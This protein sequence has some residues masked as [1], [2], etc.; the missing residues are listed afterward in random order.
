MKKKYLIIIFIIALIVFP[1]FGFSQISNNKNARHFAKAKTAYISNDTE[2]AK[3]LLKKIIKKDSVFVEAW[4]L[5]GDIYL[6]TK[7]TDEAVIAYEKAISIDAGFFPSA[8]RIVGDIEYS[9]GRFEKA[10]ENFETFLSL[11]NISP[12]AKN[13]VQVKLKKSQFAQYL[14]SHPVQFNP[15][16]FGDSINTEFDEYINSFSINESELFFTK[17]QPS[18]NYTKEHP[19]F[20]EKICY[21]NKTDSIWN[22]AKI[23]DKFSVESGSIGALCLSPD[24]RYLFFSGCHLNDGFGSC[25]LYYSKKSGDGWQKP[26][27]LGNFVNSNSWES[28]PCFSSDGKT[29]YFASNRTGGKGSSDIWKTEIINDKWSKPVNLGDSINTKKAEMSPFIHFDN[30]TLYFSSKGHPGM[31]KADLFVSRKDENGN[32][33]KPKNLGYPIN[34]IF[35]EINIVINANGKTAYI[36]S[37]LPGGKGKFDIY[38]FDFYEEVRSK[39]VSYIKGV[40]FDYETKKPL[41]ANFELIELS[42]SE[43]VVNSFSDPENG[44]FLV[45]LPTGKQYALNVSKSNYL[46][47]SDHFQLSDEYFSLEPIVK[48]IPLKPIKAGATIVLKNIFYKTDKYLLKKTSKTELNILIEFLNLNKNVKLEISGH[49]DNTGSKEHNI[50]LSK[51]RAK[52]VYDYLIEN[53]INADRLESTGFGYSKPVDTNQ[54]EEGKANNRRTEIKVLGY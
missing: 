24:L 11:E 47:Y 16:N 26:V 44:K 54:T 15:V 9:N 2:K 49:T 29:L 7:N 32:W 14:F 18:K 20:D 33:Q 45:V 21:S 23:F 10:I 25:D 38:Q 42:K 35:D 27:N 6:D 39:K 53:G 8:C 30:Q 13:S 3:K 5:L 22:K 36:S 1:N 52:S 19:V 51:N 48:N 41:E 43:I 37:D 4:L 31:G 40:V 46:F 17:K 34:T 50:T 12:Q 28:Q